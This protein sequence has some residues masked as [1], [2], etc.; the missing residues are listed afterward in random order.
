MA[1]RLS[2]NNG[3]SAVP[4]AMAPEA[5]GVPRRRAAGDPGFA[6]AGGPYDLRG[7]ANLRQLRWAGRMV[8]TSR[9]RHPLPFPGRGCD[10]HPTRVGR[11]GA[12]PAHG[13]HFAHPAVPGPAAGPGRLGPVRPPVPPPPVRL[14]PPARVPGGGRR[15]R[16]PGRPG[17]AAR[18]PT[19]VR[20][21]GGPEV[22]VL[23]VRRGPEPVPGL[24]PAEGH[25]A[26]AG[27][28][29]LPE[30]AEVRGEG[31]LSEEQHRQALLR[32]WTPSGQTSSRPPGP[33]S[34]ASR[35]TAWRPRP[36]R[37]RPWRPNWGSARTPSTWPAT[38]SSPGSSRT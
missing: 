12:R 27:D 38:G 8:S 36:W 30:V 16:G 26:P 28:E 32:G 20:A 15:G 35:W 10:N 22:P 5:V 34:P 21:A 18:D 7:R 29:A 14:C 31:E 25:P 4:V 33:P 17:P 2:L 11:P 6:A 1:S 23:A 9:G 19:R 3:V 24:P 13:H 37:P